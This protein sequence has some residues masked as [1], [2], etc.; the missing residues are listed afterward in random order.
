MEA[1]KGCLLMGY[2]EFVRHGGKFFLCLIIGAYCESPHLDW[3][4]FNADQ[5]TPHRRWVTDPGFW[6]DR[7]WSRLGHADPVQAESS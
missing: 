2:I 7:L 4:W 1:D 5:S 3:L 6:F